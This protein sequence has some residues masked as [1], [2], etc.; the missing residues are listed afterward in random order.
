MT[1]APAGGS[2]DMEDRII[3]SLTGKAKCVYDKLKTTN[4]NLFK[5]T[6]AKFI[7]DPEYNLILSIGLLPEANFGADALTLDRVSSNDEIRIV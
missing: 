1:L 3:N 7:D 4:G 2:V 6:I 5:K